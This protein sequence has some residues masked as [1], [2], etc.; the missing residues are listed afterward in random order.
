M[1]ARALSVVIALGVCATAAAQTPVVTVKAPAD[2]GG[3]LFAPK[4]DRVAASVGR[5]R[6]SVWSVIDG[7]LIQTLEVPARPAAKL[8]AA[9]GDQLLVALPDGTIEL[10]AIASG[11]TV[12]RMKA[13]A[14]QSTL[15][16]TD[17][18]RLLA[19]A[20]GERITL[21]DGSG[22]VTRTFGHEFGDVA[23]L[24]FSPDG[25]VLASA[26]LDAN[27][28]L[29]DVATGQRKASVP[30]Q[31]V[32]TLALTFTADG[33]SLLMAGVAG[34]IEVV[35]VATASV[36]RRL[37]AQKCAVFGLSVSPDGKTLAAA[38][39]DVDGATRPAPVIIWDLGSGR[40]LRR[41]VPGTPEAT[42]FG[43]DGQLRYVLMK[44]PELT[45]GAAAPPANRRSGS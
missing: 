44:G 16:A 36:T 20:A 41:L 29:W 17:D 34:T 23:A 18:G 6:V 21:W 43:P 15:A 7:R 11:A 9:G 5:D 3:P 32:A 40:L 13:D 26:G 4:G 30:D 31:L 19:S 8:F 1:T 22:R 38:C 35:D 39:F 24:A 42:G 25:S 37:P 45:I 33:K 10:R 14:A 2:I 28:H 12:R 27:V